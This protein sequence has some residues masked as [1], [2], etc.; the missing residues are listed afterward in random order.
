MKNIILSIMLALSLLAFIT[1]SHAV[2]SSTINQNEYACNSSNTAWN[3]T[4]PIILSTDI[5]VYTIDSMGNATQQTSNFSINTFTQTVTYPVT[6]SPCATGNSLLLERI[7]PFTQLVAAS[8]QGP[9]PSPVVMTMSDKLTMLAQQLNNNNVQS[10]PGTAG[11]VVLPAYSAG[12]LLAWSSTLNQLANVSNPSILAQW[13]L[14][15]ADIS[16]NT[17]NVSTINT[18][19]AKNILSTGSTA[20]SFVGNV[21]IG[22]V[23]PGSLLDVQGT[24]RFLSGNVGIGTDSTPDSTLEVTQKTG[25]APLMV[26]STSTT[27]GD[28]LIVNTGGN[29]GIGSVN[30]SQILDVNGTVR[31]TNLSGAG[32]G[33][34]GTAASLTVGHV[35]NNA[36]ISGNQLGA[37]NPYSSGTTPWT[38][39]TIYTA[40][41]DGFVY[42]NEATSTGAETVNLLV[43]SV[44]RSSL[45]F[46]GA[47]NVDSPLS[48][49]VQ[50]GQTWEVTVS[51]G[52]IDHIYWVPSGS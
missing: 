29:V 42:I 33:L 38:T 26:S 36:N 45:E 46:T 24:T 28:Y 21:G 5:Q 47:D 18:F 25:T 35:T 19:T 2:V 17:G 31:A 9:A 12:S 14:S 11:N 37:Y 51:G 32:T 44:A 13:T 23:T 30:P 39:G 41:T 1:P 6:G 27:N 20:S 40:T 8:N 10:S 34:T 49:A 48:A 22:S 16:Y 3:Y 43:N 52:S 15:G 7:E 50:K 4:F